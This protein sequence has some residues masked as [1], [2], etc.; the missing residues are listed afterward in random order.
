[1]AKTLLDK[2][3]Y[4]IPPSGGFRIDPLTG[5]V[6][7]TMFITSRLS[8]PAVVAAAH[9]FA[10][11]MQA[12]GLPVVN[13]PQ[14]DLDFNLIAHTYL[15]DI[16]ID[17]QASSSAP[18][19]LYNLFDSK[20]DIAPVP[21][22][23][24]LFGY[25][26]P[27]F[28]SNVSVFM[29]SPDHVASENAV[30]RCQQ[31]LANDLPV[32]PLFSKSILIAANSGLTVQQVV[33][34]LMETIRMTALD[35]IQST[36]SSLLRIGITSLFDTLDP[37]TTSSQ[38]DWIA[39]HLLT[40]PLLT[41]D[42]AGNLKPDLAQQWSINSD[43]THVNISLRKDV[44]FTNGQD[45]TPD[46]FVATLNWLISN[47]KISSPVY[48][49]TREVSSVNVSNQ[50]VSIDLSYPDQH[51]IYSL[52]DLFALPRQRLSADLSQGFLD[53]QL[54]VASGPFVLR[55]FTQRQGVYLQTNAEYFDRSNQ[56]KNI[57]SFQE[58][59]F[60]P[61]SSVRISSIPI[62]INGQPILNG[63][64]MICAYDQTGVTTECSTTNQTQNEV[65]STILTIDSR[66]HSGPYRI[67]SSLYAV[68]PNG[69]LMVF[70]AQEMTVIASLTIPMI[71]AVAL[72]IIIAAFVKR[73]ELSSFIL[74]KDVSRTGSSMDFY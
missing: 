17:S 25:D 39:L 24:N 53:D 61:S 44:R 40:E 52:A 64:F 21:L 58:S 23:T 35:V 29:S 32:L 49:V 31:I 4:K 26:N 46:D 68:L 9:L 71:F 51:V 13:L 69:T 15:F 18:V 41:H 50:T 54:L 72:I 63:S 65:Y 37:S 55:E 66:F 12:I 14:A 73:R 42:E 34:S 36:H 30:D 28:D 48:P 33:G 7:R 22:G 6:M 20:N 38:A 67:E 10:K 1:M 59:G 5:S 45:I 2:G 11:D 47:A 19:W 16:L 8:E 70:G 62:T 57:Y 27:D 60:T 3:G 74:R 43:G 56:I